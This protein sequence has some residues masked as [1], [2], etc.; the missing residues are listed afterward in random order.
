MPQNDTKK[1]GARKTN[2]HV[3]SGTNSTLK[4]FVISGVVRGRG[5]VGARTLERRPWGRTSPLFTVI[6]KRMLS[7]N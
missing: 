6:L 2:K 3:Y 5:Q 4:C 7:R 1:G